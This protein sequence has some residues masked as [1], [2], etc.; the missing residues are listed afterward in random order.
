MEIVNLLKSLV[1]MIVELFK[2]IPQ[3]LNDLIMVISLV[4]DTVARL[5]TIFQVFPQVIS[6]ILI[7]CFGVVIIYKV[8]GREG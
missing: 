3:L 8:L 6:S 7:A 5:P 4:T 1:N 2:F